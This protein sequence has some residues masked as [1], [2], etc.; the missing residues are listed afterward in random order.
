MR[1]TENGRRGVTDE[2]V[3]IAA[4]G[5]RPQY[6]RVCGVDLQRTGDEA[7]KLERCAYLRCVV[8]RISGVDAVD[9]FLLR[10]DVCHG[11]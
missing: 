2:F 9:R 11:H 8:R 10:G 3:G 6:G 7:G 4:V 1:V 5:G